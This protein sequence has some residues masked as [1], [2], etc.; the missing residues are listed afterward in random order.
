MDSLRSLIV[1]VDFSEP[2]NA[3]VNRA[4][5]LARLDGASIHLVH[6]ITSKLLESP[7]EVSVPDAVREGVQRAATGR[8]EALRKHTEADGANSVTTEIVETNDPV[9][10]IEQ[11]VAAHRGDLVVMGTHGH[12]P[13][14]RAWLGSVAERTIRSLSCPVLAVREDQEATDIRRILVPVDFS[15]HSEEAAASA[16]ALAARCDAT[17]DLLYAH[18]VSELAAARTPYAMEL[19]EKIQHE[20]SEKLEQLAQATG[21]PEV[22]TESHVV[23]GAP[24]AVI[25]AEAA[26]RNVDLIVMGTHGR[27]GL[28]HL[29]LGSV[30]ERT[31]RTA[32]CPVLAVKAAEPS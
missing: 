20:A 32:P 1:P 27:T 9:S 11:A 15:A 23:R 4:I 22:Q 13:I 10:A 17:V 2:S 3:A 12:G 28:A 5:A 19:D 24:A 26:S 6:A 7:Y 14:A 31:L 16:S 30:T 25:V 18:L 29:F 21:R 8:M